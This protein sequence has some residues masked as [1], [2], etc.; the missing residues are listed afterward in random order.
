MNDHN[1]YSI[2]PARIEPGDGVNGHRA[3]ELTDERRYPK[4]GELYCF[5]Y[6]GGDRAEVHGPFWLKDWQAQAEPFGTE[7]A[8][9]WGYLPF[10]FAIYKEAQ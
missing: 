6:I 4:A 8:L 3:L 1:V 5:L 9:T 7:A 10:H 2:F